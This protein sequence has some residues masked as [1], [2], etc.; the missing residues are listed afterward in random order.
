VL[1]NLF[2]LLCKVLTKSRVDQQGTGGLVRVRS[3]G[4]RYDSALSSFTGSGA[5]SDSDASLTLARLVR[6]A[7]RLQHTNAGGH[8]VGV[9]L[10]EVKKPRCG[11]TEGK[12][13]GGRE[14]EK[15]GYVGHYR[16][17]GRGGA[18][19]LPGCWH[20]GGT[21][22][23]AALSKETKRFSFL[24]PPEWRKSHSTISPSFLVYLVWVN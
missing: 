19:T 10:S 12:K 11:K 7:S 17:N 21:N 8:V 4:N 1:P 2:Q 24:F 16:G 5:E 23:C 3:V 18:R 20:H 13:V 15:E 22:G 6:A 14:D 9:V